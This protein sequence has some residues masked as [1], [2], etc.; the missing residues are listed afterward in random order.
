[1]HEYQPVLLTC[2]YITLPSLLILEFDV[3]M[4]QVPVAWAGFYARFNNFSLTMDFVGWNTPRKLHF[5]S[6]G[7]IPD[8][9]ANVTSFIGPVVTVQSS[10]GIPAERWTNFPLTPS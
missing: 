6:C 2:D 8:P 10:L 5:H 3:D 1:V 7:N 9:G 4:L